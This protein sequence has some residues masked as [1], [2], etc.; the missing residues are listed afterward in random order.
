MR[1]Q[2]VRITRAE[3]GYQVEVK[4]PEILKKNEADDKYRDANVSYVF[5]DMSGLTKFLD[6]NLDKV[7][8]PLDE[9]YTSGFKLALKE[10]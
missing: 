3:N 2:T 7:L 4:D 5:A 6:E 1:D 8:A 10:K 9:E